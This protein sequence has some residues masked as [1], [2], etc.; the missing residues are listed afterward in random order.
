MYEAAKEQASVAVDSLKISAEETL[1]GRGIKRARKKKKFKKYPLFSKR[2][3]D[4][5]DE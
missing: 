5:Y 4:I 3:T 2:P 1:E